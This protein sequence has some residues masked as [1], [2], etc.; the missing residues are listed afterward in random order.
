MSP[1]TLALLLSAQQP[2]TYCPV[3]VYRDYHFGAVYKAVPR[4]PTTCQGTARVRKSSTI[5]V[6]RNGAPYQPV[7]P[8]IGAWDVTRTKTNIPPR[9]LWTLT[10]WRWEYW[11]GSRWRGA[12]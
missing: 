11:D 8:E 5:N 2:T 7:K 4:L 10:T 1:L 3:I 6:R 12:L 9:E